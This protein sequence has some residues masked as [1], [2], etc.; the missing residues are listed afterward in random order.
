MI[1]AKLR[2]SQFEKIFCTDS[3]NMKSFLVKDFYL[4]GTSLEPTTT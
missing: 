1:T 2:L 4:R 3:K